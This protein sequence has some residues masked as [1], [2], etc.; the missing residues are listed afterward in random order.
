MLKASF[1]IQYF[2]NL[3]L[4]LGHPWLANYHDV[5]VPTD[6]IVFKLVKA[7]IC[8]SSLRKSALGVR[9]VIYDMIDYFG[10]FSSCLDVSYIYSLNCYRM[11]RTDYDLVQN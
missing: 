3:F 4:C 2:D 9:S 1:V 7:Y 11:T 8:S 10:M 6:M 5:K